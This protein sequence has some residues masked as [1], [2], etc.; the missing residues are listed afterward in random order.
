MSGKYITLSDPIYDYL[1]NH[2]HPGPDEVLRD[3]IQETGSMYAGNCRALRLS[4]TIQE[5]A[6]ET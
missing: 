4:T 2:L 1:Q 5:I 6:R 3:L